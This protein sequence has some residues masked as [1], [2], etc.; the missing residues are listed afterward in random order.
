MDYRYDT[1]KSIR[2]FHKQRI[3]FIIINDEIIFINN[4]MVL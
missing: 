1:K 2:D 4:K 3:A